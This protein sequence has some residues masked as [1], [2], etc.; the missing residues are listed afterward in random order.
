[1][2]RVFGP[3]ALPKQATL[4]SQQQPAPSRQS[5]RGE[6]SRDAAARS[7]CRPSS[8][9]TP[10]RTRIPR[11]FPM[12]PPGYAGAALGPRTI[13][14]QRSAAD[15]HGQ[16]HRRSTCLLAGSVT[17]WTSLTTTR[18]T[19]SA[20]AM[21]QTA[22]TGEG[23]AGAIRPRPR[24]RALP[25]G[26]ARPAA[27]QVQRRSAPAACRSRPRTQH[28]SGPSPIVVRT[29]SSSSRPALWPGSDTMVTGAPA[30][31]CSRRTCLVWRK[32]AR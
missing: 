3:P 20:A 12:D 13:Q 24:G 17:A 9:A 19:G 21:A 16:R 1:M 32:A 26:H 28:M 22:A 11:N 25:P 8:I 18:S 10:P 6:P 27:G 14:V 31:P 23:T 4:S 29:V 5:S 2:P 15:N 30:S 7:P